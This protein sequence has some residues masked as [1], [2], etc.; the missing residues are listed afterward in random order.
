M[1]QTSIRK[2]KKNF[3][4]SKNANYDINFECEEYGLVK[5]L[6]GNCRVN[7]ICNSGDEVM[8]I[9]RGNMR[10][11]NKRVLI[12]KGDIVV[13][14]KRE[15]QAGKVDIVHKISADKH[16]EVLNSTHF[17]NV[18]INEYYNAT[19]ASLN[20]KETYI[21]FNDSC[22]DV[23]GDESYKSVRFLNSNDNNDNSDSDDNVDIDNI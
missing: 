2:K 21:N 11:F 5:K 19:N 12:D 20:N 23:S 9:I 8:G 10:K 3:N 16:S 17:S 15:Y 7:L 13:I 22:S 4:T 6:L 18:L 1:Y 14:S